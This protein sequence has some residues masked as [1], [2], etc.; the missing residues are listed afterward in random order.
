MPK[1]MYVAALAWVSCQ[2]PEDKKSVFND[3]W[4]VYTKELYRQVQELDDAQPGCYKTVIKGEDIHTE[5]LDSCDFAQE[6]AVFLN[7]DLALAEKR[8]G[9]YRETLDSSQGLSLLRFECSDTTAD[10]R[11]F[12]V[13]KKQGLVQLL[14]WEIQTRS[15]LMDRFMKLSV[16]PGKGYRIWVRENALW[17]SPVEYEIFTELHNPEHLQTR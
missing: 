4:S 2:T 3:Q 7:Y 12:Q 1:W 16:Q 6:F 15:F 10:L 13:L 14:E 9:A 5:E 11:Q 17:A 8:F